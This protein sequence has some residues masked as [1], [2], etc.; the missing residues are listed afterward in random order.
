MGIESD[1]S[2]TPEDWTEEV[3]EEAAPPVFA[4]GTLMYARP[5][6]HLV[7][8]ETVWCP[9]CKGKGRRGP[10]PCTR[11]LGYGIIPNVGPIAP[12]KNP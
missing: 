2:D 7:F 4:P 5:P 1:R 9:Y 3:E 8:G 6:E 11:C 10:T 12:P